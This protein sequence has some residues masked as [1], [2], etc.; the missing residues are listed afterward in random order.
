M[1]LPWEERYSEFEA[2]TEHGTYSIDA[3]DSLGRRQ[4]DFW[5]GPNKHFVAITH[6]EDE[7][8]A[9]ADRHFTWL[10]HV[11]SKEQS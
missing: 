8:K 2:V 10:L 3:P 5:L 7:A 1:P 4:V 9:A 11:S 6:G